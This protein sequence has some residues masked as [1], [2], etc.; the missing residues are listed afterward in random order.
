VNGERGSLARLERHLARLLVTGVL[1]SA[2]LLAAGL[3]LWLTRPD[4]TARGLLSAGLIA[5]MATPVLRVFVSLAE[6][7]R[8]RDWL[9]VAT[10]LVV[11]VELTVPVV[12]A[13]THG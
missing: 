8:I 11:L 12:L 10:T 6:Y 1:V 9:F 3:A 5:L 7:L 4:A 13:L 2:A